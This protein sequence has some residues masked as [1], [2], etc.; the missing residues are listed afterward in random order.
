MYF[1]T[2]YTTSMFVLDP[3]DMQHNFNLYSQSEVDV[4][5]IPYDVDSIMHYG[6]YD[7]AINRN[8]PVIQPRDSSISLSRLGQRDKLS[9]YDIM[10]VNIRYCPGMDVTVSFMYIYMMCTCFVNS[11]YCVLYVNSF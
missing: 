9:P 2:I 4:Q 10:Q 3:T 1:D 7:F 6:P 5:G 11:Q 8:V